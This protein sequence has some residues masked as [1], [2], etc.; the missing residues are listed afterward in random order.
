MGAKVRAANDGARGIEAFESFLPGLVFLDLGMPGLDGFET[1]RRLRSSPA[2]KA[3]TLVALTGWGGEETRR[4]T[5]EAGFDL[6][7]TKPASLE[8]IKKA[9][10]FARA[11]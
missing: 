3:A 7:M 1:A 10:S 9:L 6:H 2:G 5:R 4:R 8:D 11:C